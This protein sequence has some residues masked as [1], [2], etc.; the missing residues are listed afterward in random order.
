VTPAVIA[1]CPELGRDLSQLLRAVPHAIVYRAPRTDNG[2]DGCIAAH[3][4]IVQMARDRGWSSV[5][6]MED[7]CSFTEAFDLK[8]WERDIRWAG[9][10]GYDVLA[11][12]C[13][14]TRNP[15]LVRDGLF[16][17]ERFKSTHCVAYHS[18]A[19]DIVDRVVPPIDLQ[20]GTLG[21]KCVVTFPYVAVQGP[22]VSGILN[23]PVDYRPMYARH[24]AQLALLA[25]RSRA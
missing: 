23:R 14:S 18:G 5:F 16:A 7:D 8:R 4:G 17:V 13:V 1:H 15:T 21:A 24:E 12:G 10:R 20:L 25:A 3:R 9:K 2:H 6:V 11:G 22:S 19:F